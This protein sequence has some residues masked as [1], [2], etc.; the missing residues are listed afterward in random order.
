[1]FSLEE[2]EF[3]ETLEDLEVSLLYQR[4]LPFEFDDKLISVLSV[5]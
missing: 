5:V 3:A 4:V 2:K 1:M